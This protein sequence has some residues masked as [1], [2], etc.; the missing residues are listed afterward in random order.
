M[1]IIIFIVSAVIT[2]TI[3]AM[4]SKIINPE[5]LK[6]VGIIAT[7]ILVGSVLGVLIA[8]IIIFLLIL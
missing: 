5:I 3:L 8:K 7:G 4:L 1:W 2:Y 6:E